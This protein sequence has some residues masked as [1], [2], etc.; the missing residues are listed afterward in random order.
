MFAHANVEN[1][2]DDIKKYINDA[3][4]AVVDF[5]LELAKSKDKAE[6]EE[7]NQYEQAV[8]MVSGEINQ[9]QKLSAKSIRK[10]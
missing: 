3:L 7:D 8:V 4:D 9:Q 6:K 2:V 10:V 5:N 1:R